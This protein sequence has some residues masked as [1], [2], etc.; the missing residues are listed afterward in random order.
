[1]V[2]DN[3]SPMNHLIIAFATRHNRPGLFVICAHRCY[4]LGSV[5]W[6]EHLLGNECAH[7][8]V[9]V[10]G[11]VQVNSIHCLLD[12]QDANGT[13]GMALLHARMS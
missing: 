6:L 3:T 2:L 1:M 11:E 7:K 9:S 12:T 5:S 8:R 10:V 4:S 13:S